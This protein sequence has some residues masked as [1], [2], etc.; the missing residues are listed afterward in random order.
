MKLAVRDDGTLTIRNTTQFVNIYCH[1]TVPAGEGI[2]KYPV[3]WVTC[4]RLATTTRWNWR[5]GGDGELAIVWFG[6]P[7]CEECAAWIDD[8]E[9]EARVEALAS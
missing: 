7:Y 2:T 4:N 6:T 5:F 8:L 3:T 9:R 1:R